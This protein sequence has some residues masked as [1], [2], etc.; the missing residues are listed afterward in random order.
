MHLITVDSNNNQAI[1]ESEVQDKEPITHIR[2][3]GNNNQLII[4][5]TPLI[6]TSVMRDDTFLKEL[7]NDDI[8][9]IR[10]SRSQVE[11]NVYYESSTLKLSRCDDAL[12]STH[13]IVTLDNVGTGSVEYTTSLQ[14]NGSNSV[15]A[16]YLKSNENVKIMVCGDATCSAATRED[17]TVD[18]N[19]GGIVCSVA[20]Q[21]TGPLQAAIAYNGPSGLLLATISFFTASPTL[22]PTPYPSLMPTCTH[23]L[24]YLRGTSLRGDR[25]KRQFWALQSRRTD[26]GRK[27]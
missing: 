7:M 15:V 22:S 10:S 1:L 19:V 12:C 14:L 16:Y 8:I 26:T 23:P 9:R 27:R 3:P 6:I 25:P 2:L 4:G 13:Q 11:E 17:F 18:T 5:N 20:L 24:P 21:L